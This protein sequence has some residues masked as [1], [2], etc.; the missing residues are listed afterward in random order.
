MQNLTK[1]K[2][3]GIALDIL[4]NGGERK[5]AKEKTLYST[6]SVYKRDEVTF[7]KEAIQLQK[8]Q[9]A[10]HTSKNITIDKSINVA[11]LTV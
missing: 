5:K 9:R 11:N 8:A 10:A 3:Q 7:S 6:S 1:V 2:M 4:L